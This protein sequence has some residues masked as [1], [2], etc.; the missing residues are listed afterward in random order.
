VKF[1]RALTKE[2]W[3][4]TGIFTDGKHDFP[5]GSE[6]LAT[7]S[8]GVVWHLNAEHNGETYDGYAPTDVLEISEVLATI[9]EGK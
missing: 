2:P 8:G 4:L 5:A 3:T 9:N 1:Y 6:V 7:E